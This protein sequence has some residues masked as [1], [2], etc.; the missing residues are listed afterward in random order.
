MGR[1]ARALGPA[2]TAVA[3]GPTVEDGPRLLRRQ[4]GTL[5]QQERGRRREKTGSGAAAAYKCGLLL[6]FPSPNPEKEQLETTS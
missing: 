1:T 5:R 4:Q 2:P 6:F 3:E